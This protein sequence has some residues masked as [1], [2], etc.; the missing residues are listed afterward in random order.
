MKKVL[1]FYPY[2]NT[3][4][5]IEE[6]I[7]LLSKS[8]SQRKLQ[9]VILCF[10]NKLKIQKYSKYLE[11]I[12]L[13]N[14]NYIKKIIK[15][16]LFLKA[17]KKNYQG[18]ALF[19]SYKAAFFAALINF[20]DYVLHLDDPLSLLNQ[21]N[22][23]NKKSLFSALRKCIVHVINKRGIQNAI[24]RLTQTRR[25]AQEFFKDY[26]TKFKVAYHGVS[27]DKIY[28]NKKKLINK[29][30]LTLISISRLETSKNIEWIIYGLN[31]LLNINKIYKY[32]KKIN[33]FIVGD[34]PE[35]SKLLNLVNKLKLNKSV[36]FTGFV[37]YRKKY[38][39]FSRANFFLVPAV[40]GYGLPVLEGL[41]QKIPVVINKETRISEILKNNPWVR[42]SQ[43]NKKDFIKKMR[44]HV[45]KLRFK[46]P[47]NKYLNKLPSQNEWAESIFRFC[48]W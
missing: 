14:E 7:I 21:N 46:L 31:Q 9:P 22:S 24:V 41:V 4:G 19:Y 39:L 37:T 10:S 43:N 25:N 16:K 11:V 28:L 47:D 12:E 42:I 33:L 30:K 27:L 29:K 15:L 32:Y 48:K 3:Y 17:F 23:S 26:D 6:T 18:H 35:K 8:I 1:I 2:I 34:G 36:I 13:G 20:K 5:G 38:K 44:A 40:Q 45:E